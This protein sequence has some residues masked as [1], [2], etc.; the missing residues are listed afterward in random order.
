MSFRHGKSF[1]NLSLSER[2]VVCIYS[3]HDVGANSPKP[4]RGYLVKG[5]A[6]PALIMFPNIN[7]VKHTALIP[8]LHSAF[9]LRANQ[10][11]TRTYSSVLN[12]PQTRAWQRMEEVAL[13]T[14]NAI[15][16]SILAFNV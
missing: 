8:L 6:D 7:T 4:F 3:F 9:H 14:C 12:F 11:Y 2:V 1:C 10:T 13:L 15:S 5:R 16:D